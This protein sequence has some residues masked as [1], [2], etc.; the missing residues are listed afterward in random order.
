MRVKSF[1]EVLKE[2]RGKPIVVANRGIPARRICR[3]ITEMFE[4]VAVMTATD[5]DKTSPATTGAHELLLLGEDPRSY[6][7]LDLII[8]L[9]RDRGAIAIHPGW[10]FAAEDDTFPAKCAEAGI[11]FIGPTREAMHTLGNKV[12]VRKLAEELGIPVVPG[13]PEAVSVPEAREIAKKIGFPIMLKAEGG[14][15]GR[16]IYEVFSEE[17]GRAHV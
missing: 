7:N 9:A 13:S 15:G 16:G 14:G 12:A 10:G 17:I 6:L 5:T 2:L 3:S 1:E 4:G 8:K 11:A